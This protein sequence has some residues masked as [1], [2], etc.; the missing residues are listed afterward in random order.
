[1][2]EV[3]TDGRAQ[4]AL[5]ASLLHYEITTIPALKAELAARGIPMR[6]AADPVGAE[7]VA[8]WLG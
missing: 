5:L 3:L 2:V 7:E 8:A 1:M 4:A 6:P